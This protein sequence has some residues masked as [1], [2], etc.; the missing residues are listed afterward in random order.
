MAPI[1]GQNISPDEAVRTYMRLMADEEHETL[2]TAAPIS[3]RA[4]NGRAAASPRIRR[5]STGCPPTKALH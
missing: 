2:L 4:T 3:R 1:D 5:S